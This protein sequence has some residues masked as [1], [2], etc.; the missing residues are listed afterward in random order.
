MGFPPL[1]FLFSELSA[2]SD[3]YFFWSIECGIPQK[4]APRIIR[5]QDL[6]TNSLSN[7]AA[8]EECTEGGAEEVGRE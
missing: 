1:T 2:P 3:F 5:A 6:I 8:A 4:G 7:A